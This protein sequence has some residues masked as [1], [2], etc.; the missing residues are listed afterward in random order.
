MVDNLSASFKIFPVDMSGVVYPF[1]VP[2]RA[3]C[4]LLFVRQHPIIASRFKIIYDHW[5]LVADFYKNCFFL[6]IWS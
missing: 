2:V 5:V 3:R 6:F 4:L 1:E